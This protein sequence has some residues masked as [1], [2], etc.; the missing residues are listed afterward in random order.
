MPAESRPCAAARPDNPAGR[1]GTRQQVRAAQAAR[2]LTQQG[3]P[4]PVACTLQLIGEWWAVLIVR[5]ALRGM[6]RFEE[7]RR[8]LDISPAI[9][10]R[11]LQTLVDVG[12]MERH[13]YREHPPRDEYVLTEA[14]RALQPVIAALRGWGRLYLER[15]DDA[16]KES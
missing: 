5:D 2:Q 1:P 8:N 15:H 9:L 10:S 12:I 13:R 16:S 7:F 3:Q 14:G 4:C 11:R 6:T